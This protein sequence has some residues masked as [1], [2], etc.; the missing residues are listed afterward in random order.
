ME[1]IS[2]IISE[3]PVITENELV[4][5]L[6]RYIEKFESIKYLEF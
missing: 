2:Y 6:E 5:G 3:K 4:E 1:K